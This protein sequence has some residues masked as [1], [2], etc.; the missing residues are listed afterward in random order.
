MRVKLRWDGCF[1]VVQCGSRWSGGCLVINPNMLRSSFWTITH[2]SDHHLAT[3]LGHFANRSNDFTDNHQRDSIHS[4]GNVDVYT[5]HRG[6]NSRSRFTP[7]S[8]V[9]QNAIAT[10][11][12]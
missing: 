9:G 2:T 12:E 1:W 6:N 4:E 7:D 3:S 11:I 10:L 8:R 5:E